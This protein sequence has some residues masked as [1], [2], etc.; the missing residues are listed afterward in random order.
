ML[1]GFPQSYGLGLELTVV[2]I[3]V[4]GVGVGGRV[5]VGVGVGVV[6]DGGVS[7][8]VCLGLSLG[9]ALAVISVPSPVATIATIVASVV[10]PIGSGL[11]LSGTLAVVAAWIEER[12]LLRKF[13]CQHVLYHGIHMPY[14]KFLLTCIRRSMGSNRIPHSSTEELP[15]P[16]AQ[17]Q[18]SACRTY[19]HILPCSPHSHHSIPHRERAQPRARH[20]QS[21]CHSSWKKN[22]ISEKWSQ[23]SNLQLVAL[24]S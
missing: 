21:A 1:G 14:S 18:Q 7:L 23:K 20:Q 10:S 6:E 22:K 11:S 4:T 19:I 24:K 17:H 12:T 3:R 9:G 15:R 13:D 16:R 8:G 2:D 5:C